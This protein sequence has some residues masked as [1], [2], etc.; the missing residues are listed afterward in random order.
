MKENAISVLVVDDSALMRNV[1]S[2]FFDEAP[3]I[4]VVATAHNGVFALKKI[5]RYHPDIITLDLEMPEMDGISFLKERKKQGIDIPVIIL[6]T[7]AQ[8]GARI[9]ME[10]IALGAS[11]FIQKPSGSISQDIYTTKNQLIQLV[12]IYAKKK[13]SFITHIRPKASQDEILPMR[14][15]IKP[16][17]RK[18]G[19][20][21]IVAIGISTGGPNALRKIFPYLDADLRAPILVVQHM[22]KGFTEEFAKSLNETCPLT[23]REAKNGDVLKQGRILI[24]PGD[25]HMQV[26]SKKLANIIQLSQKPPVNGHRPSVDVLFSSIASI[27]GRR[28][29]ALIMTG[30]GK[31]GA[32]NIGLIYR[33]GGI[34]IAQDE[35]TSVVFG[36]PRVAIELGV[37]QHIIPLQ[38]MAE[39]INKLVKEVKHRS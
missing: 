14:R 16:I 39:T 9:T 34:T 33:A 12:R 10:A 17:T 30:M 11:D 28:C 36:M 25:Q 27:Y 15:Q 23:V 5:E 7:L 13:A 1:V 18:A 24:A 6:S 8:R 29:V 2:K 20:I 38:N 37:I 19:P 4:Q 22:P 3:D 26:I 31:D 35:S 21:D 32:Q